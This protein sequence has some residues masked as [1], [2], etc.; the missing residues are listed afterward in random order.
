MKGRNIDW[1]SLIENAEFDH[2][3]WRESA[4]QA[5]YYERKIFNARAHEN[6]EEER[7]ESIAP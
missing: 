4:T 2:L 6:E 1:E 7:A 5:S 3:A